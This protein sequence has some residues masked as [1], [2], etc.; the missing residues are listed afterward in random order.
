LTEHRLS[1]GRRGELVAEAF[2]TGQGYTILKRNYRC[3]EGEVDLVAREGPYLVFVEVRTKEA[4]DP[5]GPLETIDRRK[6]A[7]VR[8]VVE[9][10]LV[11]E[12]VGEVPVRIDAVGIVM[13]PEEAEPRSIQLIKDAF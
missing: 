7:Q 4:D 1:L 12:Q 10:F 6:Q 5:V 11:R 2:L 3:P 8:R 9:A 13:G